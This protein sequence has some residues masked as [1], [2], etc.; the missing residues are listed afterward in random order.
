LPANVAW[1]LADV[2]ALLDRATAYVRAKWQADALLLRFSADVQTP[3]SAAPTNTHSLDGSQDL[4]VTFRYFSPKTKQS[5]NFKPKMMGNNISPTNIS[6]EAAAHSIANAQEDLPETLT[7]M[8]IAQISSAVLGW[9]PAP[10]CLLPKAD[11]SAVDGATAASAPP[12]CPEKKRGI[13]WQIEPVGG[14]RSVVIL[15]PDT[16]QS[17]KEG[18]ALASGNVAEL[19]KLWAANPAPVVSVRH[20]TASGGGGPANLPH[21][22]PAAQG[23]QQLQE[24]ISGLTAKNGS[25]ADK[26]DAGVKV[27]QGASQL[28]HGLQGNSSAAKPNPAQTPATAVAAHPAPAKPNPTAN[29]APATNEQPGFWHNAW[30]HTGGWVVNKVKGTGACPPAPTP[31]PKAAN[32]TAPPPSATNHAA[33]TG[34]PPSP[35]TSATNHAAQTG[36]PA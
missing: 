4:T 18:S 7:R 29:C 28:V 34:H 32:K 20:F 13:G 11:S 22:G 10:A 23:A 1:P 16:E 6:T 17:D 33:Q 25:V 36:H 19:R 27:A 31:A 8:G 14:E 35:P 2:P 9:N 5:I 12:P 15:Q 26:L 30:S 24:G 3:G 21:N